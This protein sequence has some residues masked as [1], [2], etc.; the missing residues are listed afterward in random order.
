MKRFL[1]CML[2]IAGA[3]HKPGCKFILYVYHVPDL[4]FYM[5]LFKFEAASNSC[6]GNNGRRSN[7]NITKIKARP[8]RLIPA[9]KKCL[10]QLILE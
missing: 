10:L 4:I 1:S 3:S 8:R 5:M 7:A 9:E 6:W 2:E